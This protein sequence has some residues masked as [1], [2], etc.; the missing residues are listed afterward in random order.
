MSLGIS[1]LLYKKKKDQKEYHHPVYRWIL[2]GIRSIAIFFVLFLLLSPVLKSSS[3]H[4]VKPGILY[5]QDNSQSVLY[6]KDSTFAEELNGFTNVLKDK[7]D[8][9][10]SIKIFFTRIM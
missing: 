4:I 3:K 5:I 6:S 10:Y 9:T 7:I 1:A 2:F 8:E